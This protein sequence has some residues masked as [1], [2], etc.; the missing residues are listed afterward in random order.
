[1]FFLVKG[2]KEYGVNEDTAL[3]V[4]SY[5][6]LRSLKEG[7]H[8]RT[9][10]LNTCNK[11]KCVLQAIF[12]GFSICVRMNGEK[13]LHLMAVRTLQSLSLHAFAHIL[14]KCFLYQ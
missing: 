2:H 10:P 9:I 13:M 6:P 8:T 12:N 3:S 1:M 7:S 4:C 11:G 5:Y 14:V